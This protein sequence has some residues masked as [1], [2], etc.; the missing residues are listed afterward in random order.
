[1]RTYDIARVTIELRSALSIGATENDDVVDLFC[2]TDANGL[3]AIPG[4]SLTGIMRSDWEQLSNSPLPTKEVFGIQETGKDADTASRSSRLVVSWGHIHNSKDTPVEFRMAP[5]QLQSD[6]LLRQASVPMIRQHVRISHKGTASHQGLFNQEVVAAGHR[7]TFELAL[8]D[9]N[10]DVMDTLLGVLHQ[11]SLRLGGKTNRGLGRFHIVRCYRRR[12]DLSHKDDFADFARLPSDIAQPLPEGLLPKLDVETV[13]LSKDANDVR[14]IRLSIRPRGFWMIGGGIPDDND[15]FTTDRGRESTP[16][17][18]PYREPRVFW[19]NGIGTLDPEESAVV[20]PA[21]SIK[22]AIRHRSRYYAMMLQGIYADSDTLTE[23]YMENLSRNNVQEKYLEALFGAARDRVQDETSPD[24]MFHSSEK[25]SSTYQQGGRVVVEDILIQKKLENKPV[26]H[27]STS[28]FTNG[29]IDGC[30]FQELPFWSDEQGF[31]IN[32]TVHI[33]NASHIPEPSRQILEL[34]LQDLLDGH[35]QM[36]SGTG[37]GN[38]WFE[39]VDQKS[40]P[41]IHWP[42]YNPD[43][44]TELQEKLHNQ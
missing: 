43:W 19:E 38:G 42:R 9:C 11:D 32:L 22:G 3:P 16:D 8:R 4:S 34:T 7:F 44:Q 23:E 5:S 36:G 28:R 41:S 2:V 31:P 35:L 13:R 30:L 18:V 17:M 37:R 40:L 14:T 39:G 26:D 1:M 20:I 25:N 6:A 10:T 29:P 15:K 12:F 24:P 27:L 21:T 33:H